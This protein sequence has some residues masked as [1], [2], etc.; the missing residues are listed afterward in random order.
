MIDIPGSE[1]PHHEVYSK[2]RSTWANLDISSA[3]R[4]S[5]PKM[6]VRPARRTLLL[7]I[8]TSAKDFVSREDLGAVLALASAPFV[9]SFECLTD[10]IGALDIVGY[11]VAADDH[12]L[13]LS[14][15][16]S[17]IAPGNS[18][19]KENHKVF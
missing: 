2:R 13:A 17:L 4:G 1:D 5:K 3:Y 18:C 9:L 8:A 6:Q 10:A 16:P 14:F 7:G 19:K 12:W 11:V 15:A